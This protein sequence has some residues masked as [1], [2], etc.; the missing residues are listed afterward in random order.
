MCL[1][2]IYLYNQITLSIQI[3]ES[4][5]TRPYI[6][7]ADR[8]AICLDQ[9]T[10]TYMRTDSPIYGLQHMHANAHQRTRTGKEIAIL[11]VSMV[12]RSFESDSL[13]ALKNSASSADGK[14]PTSFRSNHAKVNG[15]I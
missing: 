6:A 12:L 7:A 2:C 15:A 5:C 14:T 9:N 4:M 1:G 11:V 13:S 10:H 8:K 3:P